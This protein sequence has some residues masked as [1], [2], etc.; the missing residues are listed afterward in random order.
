L[1]ACSFGIVGPLGGIL[2]G[3]TDFER[4]RRGA[5]LA[6]TVNCLVTR[7]AVS[8]RCVLL[9]F[10]LTLEIKLFG[11]A[12]LEA[13]KTNTLEPPVI[14]LTGTRSCAAS[15]KLKVKKLHIKSAQ[16]VALRRFI[17]VFI[18]RHLKTFRLF[19]PVN[20]TKQIF[21]GKYS[22][23]FERIGDVFLLFTKKGLIWEI[24]K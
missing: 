10:G 3:S 14:S 21:F 2:V 23:L 9:R 12:F 19:Y 7:L 18:G 1:A 22:I 24:K 6:I 8:M 5:A 20:V 17:F 11:T 15:G 4:S 16:I 13:R